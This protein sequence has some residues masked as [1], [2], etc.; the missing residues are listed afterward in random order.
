MGPFG[1]IRRN[2]EQGRVEEGWRWGLR[3]VSERK[4][5]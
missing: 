2:G 4:S 1:G 3:A 5:Q